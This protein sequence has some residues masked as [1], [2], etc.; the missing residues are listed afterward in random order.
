M[1]EA[2]DSSGRK[3]LQLARKA[4]EISP[5]CADAY[6]LLAEDGSRNLKEARE[7]YEQGMKAGER[8]LGAETFEEDV[9][10]FWGILETRPYM[11]ARLGL[12]QTLWQLGEREQTVDHYQDLLRLNPGDNQGVRYL[13]AMNLLE[14]EENERLERLLA[15]YEDDWSATWHYT[16]A[17]VNFR[18]EGSGGT[19][20]K[21]L[22]QAIKQNP[23]V[24]AYLLGK[25]KV[26]RDL[27]PYMG[28]GDDD[29]A[30]SYAADAIMIWRG[31]EGAIPWL[32]SVFQ[33][34]E[35][36]PKEED[37]WEEDDDFELPADDEHLDE[38]SDISIDEL[39]LKDT[40]RVKIKN[41]EDYGAIFFAVEY[42]VNLFWEEYSSLTDETVKDV[43]QQLIRD[44]DNHDGGLL[45]SAIEKGVKIVLID[46][47]D[48]RGQKYSKGEL[49]SCLS[50]LVKMLE[51]H[52]SPDGIGYL[53]WTKLFFEGELPETEEEIRKYIKEN[54]R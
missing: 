48:R 36:G 20:D 6:V 50:H 5:D 46:E 7:F 23:F 26:P 21:S 17:L 18:K 38:L 27:P 16:R 31:T 9:G 32:K 15:E 3:R 4:L 49:L 43:Y 35:P 40:R 14:M 2:W 12:A 45:C 54:E 44:F 39:V 10:H 37:L 29:E 11:R 8:A 28:I 25:K 33:E 51:N 53:K 34:H 30:V 22:V 1:Y 13:L 52:K 19:S 42:T 47:Q 41:L 24:P